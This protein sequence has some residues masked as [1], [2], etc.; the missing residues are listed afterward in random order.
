MNQFLAIACNLLKECEKKGLWF[1]FR[2]QDVI[3]FF[4]LFLIGWKTNATFLS[5]SLGIAA[6]AIA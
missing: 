6:V 1:G 2:V 5:Q 3:G 4:V